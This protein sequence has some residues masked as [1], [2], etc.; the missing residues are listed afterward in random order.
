MVGLKAKYEAGKITSK[1][2]SIPRDAKKA[3]R[4]LGAA[5]K[6]QILSGSRC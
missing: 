2:T 5:V 1:E 3:A 4:R 6:L